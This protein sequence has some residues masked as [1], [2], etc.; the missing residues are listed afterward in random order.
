[1]IRDVLRYPR[2][3]VW[4]LGMP[5]FIW[6]CHLRQIWRSWGVSPLHFLGNRVQN[7]GKAR[8]EA[9]GE[10]MFG[11]FQKY[12]RGQSGWHRVRKSE[13][14]GQELGGQLCQACQPL[15]GL[16]LSSERHGDLLEGFEQTGGMIWPMI[17]IRSEEDHSGCCVEIRLMVEWGQAGSKGGYTKTSWEPTAINPGWSWWLFGLWW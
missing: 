2:G 13:N 5:W 6:R 1:M 15:G 17:M 3:Q 16:W 11:M 10:N 7:D 4:G 12:Q 14:G 8:A 9:G